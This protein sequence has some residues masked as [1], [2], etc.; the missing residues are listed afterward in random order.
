[1]NMRTKDTMKTRRNILFAGILLSV[2]T[3]TV[4]V[5]LSILLS[6]ENYDFLGYLIGVI[7][8][9]FYSYIIPIIILSISIY[10]L[11]KNLNRRIHPAV[12]IFLS[13]LAVF[14]YLLPAFLLHAIVYPTVFSFSDVVIW[15]FITL[16][17]ETS[18]M[19]LL[20]Y[21]RG[22]KLFGAL[23]FPFVII[24]LFLLALLLGIPYVGYSLLILISSLFIVLALIDRKERITDLISLVGYNFMWVTV[25]I[26]M[27]G[28]LKIVI[29]MGIFG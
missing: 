5:S 19:L 11:S 25:L 2:F 22:I 16:L 17:I 24:L 26:F 29:Y 8:G 13:F 20:K 10:L 27:L 28:V 6:G 3:F 1:M 9:A 21:E 23:S 15:V 4:N 12:V 14:L 7:I 18:S